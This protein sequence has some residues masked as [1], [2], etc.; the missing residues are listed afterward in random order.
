MQF[1]NLKSKEA[2]ILEETAK[3]SPGGDEAL[4]NVMAQTSKQTLEV[5]KAAADNSDLILQ[6]DLHMTKNT[7]SLC[8]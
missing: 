8:M 6:R 5:L 4:C 3:H 7:V 1:P 2:R